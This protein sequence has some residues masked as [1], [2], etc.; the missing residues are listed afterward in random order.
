MGHCQGVF[1]FTTTEWD[2]QLMAGYDLPLL[3]EKPLK[4]VIDEIGNDARRY[5][6]QE[7]EHIIQ[8]YHLLSSA[9][10]GFEEQRQCYYSTKK[11]LRKN[12]LALKSA[13]PKTCGKVTWG[14]FYAR[15]IL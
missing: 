6:K 10:S 13:I 9:S 12:L 15:N 7:S 5:A 4:L 11:F 14:F 3:F 1:V 2:F 8:N